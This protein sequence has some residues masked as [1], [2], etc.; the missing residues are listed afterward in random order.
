MNTCMK[1]ASALLFGLLI[2]LAAAPFAFTQNAHAAEASP[3]SWFDYEIRA[4]GEYGPGAYIT[5]LADAFWDDENALNITLPATLGGEPLVYVSIPEG[6]AETLDASQATSLAYLDCS[7]C[8][9]KELIL[10][11]LTNL[12]YLDCSRNYLTSLDASDCQLTTTNCSYNMLTEDSCAGIHVVSMQ[13]TDISDAVVTVKS[14]TYNGDGHFYNEDFDMSATI[15]ETE[16]VPFDSNSWTGDF[17]AYDV[18]AQSADDNNG[19]VNRA[20]TYTMVIAGMADESLEF[21]RDPMCDY[22]GQATGTYVIKPATLTGAMVTVP[23][24]AYTGAIQKP[25]PTV[26]VS[27]V[28]QNKSE[29]TTKYYKKQYG[30]AAVSP[31]AIGNY[32]AKVTAGTK[33]NT[34]GTVWEKFTIKPGVP[35]NFT[36]TKLNNGFKAK[37]GMKSSA[38]ASGYQVS[39]KLTTSS[40]WTTKTIVGYKNNVKSYTGLKDKKTYQVKVRTYKTVNGTRFY[41]NWSAVKKVTTK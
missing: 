20:G 34:K 10:T 28:A 23:S 14:T 22:Y 3:E 29:Y 26:K 24:K 4:D 6:Y 1:K 9:T 35:T 39:Y 40:K 30:T 7:L 13:R 12:T 31:K 36:L 27:G 41:S 15:G 2:A 16:L 33:A 18:I 19:K 21:L 32:W 37:W 38:G 5:G 17:T 11:G 25:A 8:E